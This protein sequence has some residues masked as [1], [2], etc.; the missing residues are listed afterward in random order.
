MRLSGYRTK[1]R[2]EA[3]KVFE[4]TKSNEVLI[5]EITKLTS[6]KTGEGVSID[7]SYLKGS[8]KT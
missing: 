6:D 7:V 4:K 8:K 5:V 1:S 2:T 3:K